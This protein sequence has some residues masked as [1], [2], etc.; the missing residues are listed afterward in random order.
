MVVFLLVLFSSN[1]ESKL[2]YNVHTT[3]IQGVYSPS[4]IL[5]VFIH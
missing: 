4:Y 1:L 5:R 3:S 2:H